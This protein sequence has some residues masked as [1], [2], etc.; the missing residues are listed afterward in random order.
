MHKFVRRNQCQNLQQ[1]MS[2]YVIFSN[3]NSFMGLKNGFGLITPMPKFWRWR[4]KFYRIGSRTS[5][6]RCDAETSGEPKKIARRIAGDV[7]VHT[8]KLI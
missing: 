1:K 3:E 5:H 7:N 2:F 6:F 4:N 8:F